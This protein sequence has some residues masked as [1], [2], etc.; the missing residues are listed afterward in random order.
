MKH[1]SEAPVEEFL[2]D[3]GVMNPEFAAAYNASKVKFLIARSGSLVRFHRG[4]LIEWAK[5]QQ[6]N[7]S[8]ATPRS[9]T[10]EE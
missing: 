5:G 1:Y 3:L 6:Q 8:K 2:S 4:E 10:V 9:L 7:S